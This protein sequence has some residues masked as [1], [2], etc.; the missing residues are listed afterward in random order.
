MGDTMPTQVPFP[1]KVAGVLHALVIRLE[2]QRSQSAPKKKDTHNS[3]NVN[4]MI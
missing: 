2:K 3:R 1:T 4:F